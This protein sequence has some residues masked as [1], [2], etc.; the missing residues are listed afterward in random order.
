MSALAGTRGSVSKKRH[1]SVKALLAAHL[2]ETNPKKIIRRLAREK[3]AYAKACGWSGPP[4]C[5]K[6]LASIFGIRCKE[7]QHDI[8]GD[9]RILQYPT[10]KIWIE[11]HTNRIPER[12]R[13]TIFHEFAHTLFPDYCQFLPH[14]HNE[15]AALSDDE[16]EFE[17]LCDVAAAEML[18]PVDEFKMDLNSFDLLGFEAIHDLRKRYVASIDATTYRLI[19]LTDSVPCAAIFLVDRKGTHAGRGPLWV[20]NCSKN[21]QFKYYFRPGTSPPPNSVIVHCYRNGVQT[22]DPVKETWWIN[23]QPR[24]WLVQA[25]KLPEMPHLPEYPKIVT[26][27]F[28]SSY[29][30]KRPRGTANV[31]APE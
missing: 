22:T 6:Q 28:P 21:S 29:G 26:L 4:F 8:R 2:G 13:F 18:L 3:I 14:H 19:E 11:Y 7:V 16:K 17:T 23:G 24:T 30:T 15:V 12:Q 9:G 31:L 10:G 20:K 25:T 1:E 5:P 27:I